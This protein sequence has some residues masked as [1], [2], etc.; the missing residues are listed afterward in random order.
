LVGINKT[1]ASLVDGID[2]VINSLGG[3]K[4]I[5]LTIGSILGMVFSK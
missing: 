4:G 3:L 1:L 5:G 2:N